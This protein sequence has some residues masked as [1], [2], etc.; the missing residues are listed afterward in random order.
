MDELQRRASLQLS[1]VSAALEARHY[2]ERQLVAEELH[3]AET[4]LSAA[5]QLSISD[6]RRVLAAEK[7]AAA[8]R[9]VLQQQSRSAADAAA[10]EVAVR[11][12]LQVALARAAAAE[13]MA[14]T[15]KV[16]WRQ[17]CRAALMSHGPLGPAA[18]RVPLGCQPLSPSARRYNLHQPSPTPIR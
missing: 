2:R 12:Q 18:S 7:A 11:E 3:A 4:L 5:A 9:E 6:E 8:A 17:P 10:A 14:A 13:S 15:A 16:S 1:L